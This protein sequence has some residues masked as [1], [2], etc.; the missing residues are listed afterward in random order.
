MPTGFTHGVGTGE[1][2]DFKEYAL[3]CARAFG[4][5]IALRDSALSSEIPEFEVS[6]YHSEQLERAKQ[7]LKEFMEMSEAQQRELCDKEH[8]ERVASLSQSDSGVSETRKRYEAMLAKAKE[9]KPPSSDHEDLAKFLISQLEE[10]IKWDCRDSN[11]DLYDKMLEPPV[12]ETWKEKS[13][14][15]FHCDIAY[16]QEKH[17]EEVAR[18]EF[19]NK[20]VRQLKEA[21]G[22]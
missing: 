14:Q 15:E 7:E 9:F 17:N 5:C 16:H 6:E 22:V 20:W 2:T 8:A 21:L 10:T 12:F 13:I 4:P 3:L 18:V 11:K 19:N 1:V